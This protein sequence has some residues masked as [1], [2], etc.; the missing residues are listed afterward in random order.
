MCFFGTDCDGH[1]LNTFRCPEGKVIR[2]FAAVGIQSVSWYVYCIVQK[3]EREFTAVVALY[4]ILTLS[5][6]KFT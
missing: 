1:I 3:P 4:N 5:L 2:I 6:F